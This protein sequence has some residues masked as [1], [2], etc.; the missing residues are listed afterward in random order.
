MPDAGP[1]K[2]VFISYRRSVH[3]HLSLLLFKDLRARGF[4]TFRDSDTMGAG[5]FEK[6]ILNQI[7]ARTHF[8]VL[9][10]YGTLERCSEPGDWLRR[11]I[12]Y[13]LDTGRNIIPVLVDGFK[14]NDAEK[15]LTDKLS[16]LKD[17]QAQ[18]LYTEETELYEVGLD[19]LANQKLRMPI[20]APELHRV[21]PA[22]E[23]KVEQ[24]IEEAINAPTP[25]QEELTAEQYFARGYLKGETGDLEGALADY[26]EAIR[27]N[28]EY[29]EAYNNRGI[30]RRRKGDLDGAIADYDEAIRLNPEYANAYNN[31]GIARY[32]KGDLDGAMADYD[33]AIRLKPQDAT[34]Y[35]N[36]GNLRMHKGDLDGAIAD[37]DEAIRLNPEYAEA[38]SSN[39]AEAYFALKQYDKALAGFKKAHELD[40]KYL[41]AQAGLAITH[42]ALGNTDEAKRLWR[43][44]IEQDERFRDVEWVRQELDWTEPL[45]EAARKLIAAL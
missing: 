13:A 32:K 24:I 7:A 38:Y 29:A 1:N 30:A 42:H 43:E 25:T 26:D 36:R 10:S 6:I 9:L 18:P 34:A 28:P 45:V 15:H 4:D 22:D 33:E 37:H 11:E 27:L 17:F 41:F 14:F 16:R 35:N 31:R 5:E 8:V 40:S 19:K 12:E 2:T 20:Y 39:Q 44:L 23:R 3:K 21:L